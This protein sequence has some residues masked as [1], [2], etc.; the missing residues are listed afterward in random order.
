MAQMKAPDEIKKGLELCAV[1]K[2]QCRDCLYYGDPHC[3]SEN[4]ANVLAYIKQLEAEQSNMIED[5]MDFVNDGANNPA[6]YCA[7]A[8]E[9]CVDGRGWCKPGCATCNGFVPKVRSGE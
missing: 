8:S 9:L 6:P 7:M 3:V 5:F 1:V 2:G 4:A